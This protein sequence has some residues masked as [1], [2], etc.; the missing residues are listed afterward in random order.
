M[1]IQKNKIKIEK[2]GYGVKR[3][4][5]CPV[6]KYLWIEGAELFELSIFK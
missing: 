2:G 1:Y 6:H 3:G 4:I 5:L